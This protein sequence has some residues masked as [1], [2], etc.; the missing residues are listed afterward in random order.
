MVLHPLEI[1]LISLGV[2]ARYHSLESFVVTFLLVAFFCGTGFFRGPVALVVSLWWAGAAVAVIIQ[3]TSSLNWH[4]GS[5]ILLSVFI[6]LGVFEASLSWREGYGLAKL[7]QNLFFCGRAV[8]AFFVGHILRLFR[9]GYNTKQENFSDESRTGQRENGAGS[10]KEA[11]LPNNDNALDPY[12]I[13]SLKKGASKNE[14]TKAYRD[15]VQKYHPDKLCHLAP[16]FQEM[17]HRK[18]IEINT[19]YEY[20]SSRKVG[21]SEFH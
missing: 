14:V 3:V 10:S 2:A 1:V 8:K 11:Q 4:I 6:G 20:L 16:E 7:M 15:L 17:A 9:A 21:N 19:A 5:S 13:L 18:M 12:A